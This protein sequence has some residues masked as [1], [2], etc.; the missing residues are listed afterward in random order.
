MLHKGQILFWQSTTLSFALGLLNSKPCHCLASIIY[1]KCASISISIGDVLVGHIYFLASFDLWPCWP[2][3]TFGLTISAWTLSFLAVP[4]SH[5]VWIAGFSNSL[6]IMIH[7]HLG[8]WHSILYPSLTFHPYKVCLTCG[9]Y[10]FAISIK[11]RPS[12]FFVGLFIICFILPFIPIP[13]FN[14]T[15][16]TFAMNWKKWA[17]LCRSRGVCTNSSVFISTGAALYRL[18]THQ[19]SWSTFLQNLLI[20]HTWTKTET[21]TQAP[22]N[23]FVN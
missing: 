22:D 3:L 16:K 23:V 7:A 9:N 10:T 1:I 19:R 12:I 20:L 5:K 18:E 4:F 15:R 11:L 17:S 8:P 2:L 14:F 6:S 13:S 21:W